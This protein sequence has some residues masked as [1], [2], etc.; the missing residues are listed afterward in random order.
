MNQMHSTK[1]TKLIWGMMQ[2]QTIANSLRLIVGRNGIEGF[3]K[4]HWKSFEN[5]Q[6]PS[7]KSIKLEFVS[8]PISTKFEENFK[9]KVPLIVRFCCS[10]LNLAQ[11]FSPIVPGL[12][13]PSESMER[14]GSRKGKG[15]VGILQKCVSFFISDSFF[16]FFRVLFSK[17]V[18]SEAS[19]TQCSRPGLGTQRQSAM[20]QLF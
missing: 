3:L 4:R 17:L 10:T 14:P 2:S 18:Y 9:G 7:N 8:F 11:L 19:M 5:E 1:Y 20:F 12:Y 16:Y 15:E 13:F 6:I